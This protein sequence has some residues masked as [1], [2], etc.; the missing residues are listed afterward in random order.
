MCPAMRNFAFLQSEWPQLHEAASKAEELV[1]TDPRAAC[2]YARRALEM[3]MA[4][5]YKYD[6]KLKLPYQDNLS[7]LIHESTFK[8]VAGDAI[9]TK[10]RV[11]Q[12][13]G[14]NAVHSTRRVT[15]Y[16]RSEEHTSEL[17]SRG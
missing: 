11:I 13:Q 3:A 15:Q 5:L 12:R 9:F 8:T 14:N 4:W 7:A 1:Y 16:D 17:Q 10:A 6:A 2:F